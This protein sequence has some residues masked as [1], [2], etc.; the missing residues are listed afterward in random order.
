MAKKK[1]D[2]KSTQKSENNVKQHKASFSPF[3]LF[4][5]IAVVIFSVSALQFY[6]T[7]TSVPDLPQLDLDKCWGVNCSVDESIRK[8]RIVF[9]DAMLENIRRKFETYRR[10]TRMKSLEESASYGINSDALGQVFAHWQFKYKYP[11][12]QR[13]FNHYEHFKTK[14]QGLDVHFMHVKPQ[15]KTVKVVPVLLLHGFPSSIKEFYEA[16]PLL[17]EPRPGYDFV[18][19]IIVPSLPGFGFSQGPVRQ[20][21][22]AYQIAIMMRNLMQ[23]LGHKQYYVH[24]GNIGHNI[25]THMATLFPREVLGYH[26]TFPINFSRV[27]DL[28]W[29]VGSVFPKWVGNEFADRMYPLSEKM[30]YY[31]EEFGSLHLQSTKPDTI[32]IA[33]QD[34]PLGL[35]AY[36]IDRILAFTDPTHKLK[37]D[38]GLS[39]YNTTDLIDNVMV[40][41]S[42]GSITTAMRLYKELVKNRDIEEVLAQIPT[43]VP[44]WA[45]RPKHELYHSPDFILR[46]KYP[47]LVGVTNFDEGGHYFALE[48]PTVF[49]DDLFKA[50]NSFLKLKK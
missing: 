23:R 32:G 18:F 7:L 44:T 50:V 2:K 8:F 1:D 19:E 15:S 10:A 24:G 17:T 47:N 21:L 20:G 13:Y 12:R 46:W 31:L 26:T 45:L 30:A 22:S 16:I 49:A 40:Y 33:L 43:P 3:F 9:S 4:A 28:M 48:K 35:G 41:W 38:G 25:G 5:S 36:I 14:I 6:I 11:A 37:E 42:S 34:T 39:S 29:L 27:A